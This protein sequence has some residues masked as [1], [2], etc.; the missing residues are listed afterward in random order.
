MTAPTRPAP[1]D[2]IDAPP[3]RLRPDAIDEP[4]DAIDGSDLAADGRELARSEHDPA[5]LAGEF[6]REVELRRQAVGCQPLRQNG[7]KPRW[8]MLELSADR[9]FCTS[10]AGVPRTIELFDGLPR[11]VIEVVASRQDVDQLS[12]PSAGD[13]RRRS[14]SAPTVRRGPPWRTATG[15]SFWGIYE[16]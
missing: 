15:F 4:A 2:A 16:G 10:T 5:D 7:H 12:G 6:M 9:Q 3:G 13:E 1:A 14:L 11:I 8:G